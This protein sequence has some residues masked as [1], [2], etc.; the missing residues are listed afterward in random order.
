MNFYEAEIAKCE[1]RIKRIEENPDPAK[2]GS[3][4]ILY[5]LDRDLNIARL[6]DWREGKPFADGL[7]GPLAKAMG[8]HHLDLDVSADRSQLA[9]SQFDTIRAAGFPDYACDRTIVF[10]AMCM[11]K[12]LPPPSFLVS[13]NYAC[14]PIMLAYNALARLF[15]TPVVFWDFGLE[16]NNDTLRYA[17]DQLGE[18]IEFA[19]SKVPGIKYDE[20]KHIELQEMDGNAFSL[21]HEIYQLRKHVPC[22]IS[23]RDAFRLPM[24]PSHYPNPAKALEYFRA[25][26]D[27]MQERAEKGIGA[28]TEEK[29]RFVWAVSGP[30]YADPFAILEKRGVAVPWFQFDMAMRYSGVKYGFYGDEKEYGRRLSPLEEEARMFNCLGWASLAKRW[31]DDTVYVCRDLEVDGIIN[32][33]QV[34]CTATVGLAKILEDVAER[35]LGIPTLQIEGRQLDPTYFDPIKVHDQLNIFI[36]SCLRGKAESRKG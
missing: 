24:P 10:I 30:F 29:L 34:G 12:E 32:F 20:S 3:N 4:K 28:V 18:I 31:V 2:L 17:T 33:L 14:D 8:F 23:G 36:D 26:R 1:K 13:N 7:P 35:E 21:L 27:E 19:E 22:P 11:T 9:T 15:D 6:Q 25:W 5:E 16:A